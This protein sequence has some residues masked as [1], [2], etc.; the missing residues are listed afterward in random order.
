MKISYLVAFF[1]WVVS[2]NYLFSQGHCENIEFSP[3]CKTIVLGRLTA[4]EFFIK[5]NAT[6][7]CWHRESCPGN[8]YSMY[9]IYYIPEYADYCDRDNIKWLEDNIAKKS[10]FFVICCED[11]CYNIN[12]VDCNGSMLQCEIETLSKNHK[13]F[14]WFKPRKN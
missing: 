4:I 11:D 14:C 7:V 8:D 9:H 10:N 13:P 6:K 12:W 3:N 1:F 5:R 2:S